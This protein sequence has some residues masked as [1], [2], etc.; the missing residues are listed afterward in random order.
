ME[1]YDYTHP[2][3]WVFAGHKTAKSWLGTLIVTCHEMCEIEPTYKSANSR[4]RRTVF[5]NNE[6]N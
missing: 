4:N 6:S 1:I 5:Y 2:S 3:Y